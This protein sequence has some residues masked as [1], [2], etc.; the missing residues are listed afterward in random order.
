MLL[1]TICYLPFTAVYASI[2][3]AGD[4]SV[5]S[6]ITSGGGNLVSEGD[7]S[8]KGGIAQS[9][10]PS[11]AQITRGGTYANRLGFYNPPHFA[12]QK[13]LAASV[14]YPSA[15]IALNVSANAV[16]KEVYDIT[17][18]KNPQASPMF[19]D[20]GKIIDATNKIKH[21]EGGW[22]DA[23]P[24]NIY[25]IALFDEESFYTEPFLKPCAMSLP[26][27]DS[28]LD[29][30]ID[31]AYPP[32]RASTLKVWVL[33]EESEAWVKMPE[34]QVDTNSRLITT[35]FKIAGVYA[36]LG[37]ADT[38]V[39][40][41]YSYPVPFRPY[42]PNAGLGA[43]QTGTESDGI[44]FSNLPQKGR[45]EIYTLDGRLVK[46]IQI[47]ENLTIPK[48]KWNAATDSGSK[49]ASGVYIWRVVSDSNSKTGKLMIIW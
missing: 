43:G 9:N 49:V 28:N 15:R 7:Y 12:F 19:V 40:I 23:R 5:E 2:S 13:S 30:L 47:P 22:S 26:Y 14:Y 10:I 24:E 32:V 44:T 3:Q 1:I 42:G 8:S 21:N 16:T 45:I 41:V 46:T 33:D 6:S 17:F 4:Y 38:S 25:E 18:N 39:D 37:L 11:N 27:N 31:G 48:I 35:S 34:L 36:M 29:G 20:A